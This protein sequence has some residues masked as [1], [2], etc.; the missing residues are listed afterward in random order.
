MKNSEHKAFTDGEG[1]GLRT[2]VYLPP[3]LVPWFWSVFERRATSRAVGPSVVQNHAYFESCWIVAPLLSN[4]SRRAGLWR[5]TGS[6]LSHLG[7][8]C[9]SHL[10][11]SLTLL[12]CF[13]CS[14]GLDLLCAGEHRCCLDIL[15]ALSPFIFCS[16]H[17]H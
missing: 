10:C 4:S 5:H 3:S 15:L 9:P 7:L 1:T 14:Q 6:W 2:G 8:A 16:I 12:L 11:Q 17:P 13:M